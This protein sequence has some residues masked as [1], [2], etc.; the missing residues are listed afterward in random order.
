M[1]ENIINIAQPITIG[2]VIA[3]LFTPL[4]NNIEKLLHRHS[5]FKTRTI[6]ILALTVTII[7]MFIIIILFA[8]LLIPQFVQSIANIIKDI[9]NIIHNLTEYLNRDDSF[10]NKFTLVTG[11]DI[12]SSLESFEKTFQNN[13]LTDTLIPDILSGVV[14]TTITLFSWVMGIFV[15]IFALSSRK[16]LKEQS[17]ILIKTFL[18]DKKSKLFIDECIVA[19]RMFSK[20]FVGKIIDSSIIWLICIIAML[21]MKLPYTMLVSALVGITNII[22]IIGPYIGGVL[23]FIIILSVDAEK[24]IWFGIMVIL[25][26]QLDG[27]FIGPKCIGDSTGLDTFWVLVALLIFGGLWGIVGMLIGIP[28]MGVIHDI[29]KKLTKH[30]ISK[31]EE[32]E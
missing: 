17:I 2:L 10:I 8:L 14:S 3:Y 9:P 27:N 21:I 5:K 32:Y 19:N 15:A 29:I 7:I 20:F 16:N 12:T 23:G 1:L 25:L 18:G 22:P 24:A 11:I 28:L 4:C 30:I 13:L 26:Q 6:E 31:R